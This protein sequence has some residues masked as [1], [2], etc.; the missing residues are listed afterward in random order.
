MQC[1]L[2]ALCGAPQYVWREYEEVWKEYEVLHINGFNSA[3]EP[4]LRW[5]RVTDLGER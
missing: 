3:T 5:G 4:K 1:R 2:I